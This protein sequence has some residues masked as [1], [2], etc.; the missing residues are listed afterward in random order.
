M[1]NIFK[2]EMKY[3]MEEN[4]P[5]WL[6]KGLW[7]NTAMCSKYHG[8]FFEDFIRYYRTDR[9]NLMC[10]ITAQYRQKPTY[11]DDASSGVG[12]SIPKN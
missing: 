9:C 4:N 11:V 10:S 6:N 1:G 7:Y 12:R 3:E 5:D 8:T 2:Q